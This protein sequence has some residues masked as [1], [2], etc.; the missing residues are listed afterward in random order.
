MWCRSVDLLLV[1]GTKRKEE[2]EEE[3]AEEPEHEGGHLLRKV[4]V[5]LM[6]TCLQKTASARMRTNL[7]GPSVNREEP[8]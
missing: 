5:L 1:A 2:G 4:W 6:S 3:E 7:P 8:R